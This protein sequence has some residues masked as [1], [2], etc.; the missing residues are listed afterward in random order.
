MKKNEQNLVKGPILKTLIKLALPIMATSFIQMAYNLIDLLWI[1]RLGSKAVASVGTAGFYMWLGFGFILLTKVGA[2]V[3]VS[4]NVGAGKFDVALNYARNAI[5]INLILSIFYG[6][7]LFSTSSYLI[8][9]FDLEDIGVITGGETYLKIIAWGIPAMFF[10]NVLTGIFNGYGDSKTPFII[11]SLGLVFNIILD[12]LL[13]FGI[14]PFAPMGI[15]GAALAT[16]ISQSIVALV[17]VAF[18][19]VYKRPF[20]ISKLYGKIDYHYMIDIFKIG[21][22][23]ALHSGAFTLFS[24]LIAR[25]IAGWGPIPIAVQK[26]GSQIEAIS[27]MTASG[28]STALSTFTGQN[29]GAKNWE[30]VWKGYFSAISIMGTIGVITSLLLIFAAKPIFSVFI[31]EEEALKYGIT[32]LRILGLS[33]F[34]MCIEITTSGAFNGLGKTLPPSITSIILTGARVPAALIL[35]NEALLGLNGIW[36]SI[37]LSSVLKGTV[38]VTLYLMFLVKNPEIDHKEIFVFLKSKITKS[39]QSIL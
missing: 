39:K 11:T 7:F 36:W 15:G 16:V 1:G 25:I 38:L 2:E 14:G 5:S 8:G 32:Y 4:Q 31:A 13:I 17:Y 30:R 20:K 22:P 28:F 12:P 34:F 29:Y 6:L 19:V 33:Q 26:V 21:L 9:F 3:K 10:I 37:S 35:S 24:M 23:V 27:W 18:M